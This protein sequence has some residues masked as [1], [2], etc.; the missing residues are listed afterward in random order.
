VVLA[1]DAASVHSA[2]DAF[3]LS[4]NGVWLVAH[5]PPNRLSLVVPQGQRANQQVRT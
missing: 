5:V 1:L 2:G 3:W 4:R